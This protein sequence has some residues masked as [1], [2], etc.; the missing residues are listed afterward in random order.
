MADANRTTIESPA[1]RAELAEK[2]PLVDV[3]ELVEAITEGLLADGLRA[4]ADSVWLYGSFV[5]P[6]KEVDESE[7]RSDLDVFV[8]VPDWEL[9]VSGVAIP[10]FAPQVELPPVVA[11]FADRLDWSGVAGFENGWDCSAGEAW[12]R[13]PEP[14]RETLHRCVT[15]A[16]YAR[17]ADVEEG[18][19]RP[20]DLMVGDESQWDARLGD[21]PAVRIWRA[22]GDR[23]PGRGD[24]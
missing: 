9:P 6:G 15:T 12:D 7:A 13:L 8:V 16:F 18:L 23:S 3:D 20:Y 5:D 22:D 21:G 11:R 1:G 2:A 24:G 10:L 14:V 4:R 19:V 17:E